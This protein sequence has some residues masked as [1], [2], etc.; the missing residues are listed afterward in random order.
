MSRKTEET[1]KNI[2]S[3]DQITEIVVEMAYLKFSSRA[4]PQTPLAK[5]ALGA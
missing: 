3:C 1:A 2:K 4:Y 5:G